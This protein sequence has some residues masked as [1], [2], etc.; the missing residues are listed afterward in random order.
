VKRVLPRLLV[1]V[2]VLGGVAAGALWWL[3]SGGGDDSE[4]PTFTVTRT[5]F[6]RAVPA[7]GNLEAVEATPI[8]APQD[9]RMPLKIA[10]MVEDGSRVEAGEVVV[11]FDPIEMEQR[12]RDGRESVVQAD[13]RIA[14]ERALSSAAQGRRD[15]EAMMA[16]LEMNAAREF[17]SKDEEVFSRH[18][19]IE[20]Q[21]DVELAGARMEHARSVKGIERSVSSGKLEVLGVQERQAQMEVDRARTALANLE[22]TAPHAGLLLIHRDWQGRTVAAGDTVWPG[23]KIAEVPGVATMEAKVY[24]LEADGGTLAEGMSA[25]VVVESQPGVEYPATIKRVDTL[26]QPRDPEVPVQYFTVILSLEQTDAAIMNIGQRVRATIVLDQTDA[27]VV[28]RQAVFTGDDGSFVYRKGA[29]GFERV[30]V[31][32]GPAT[33]GRVVI[34]EGLAEGDAIALAEPPNRG[35]P[36]AGAE[37]RLTRKETDA[38]R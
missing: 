27:L 28:P 33:A 18:E 16:E 4:V 17:E 14:K 36:D 8:T 13:S 6:R 29:G 22:L 35:G 3:G 37:A 30:A 11:R 15:R 9:A 12:L 38:A 21:V 23:M 26:A 32:L 31:T 1:A 20:S 24:V 19:I 5:E 25:T 34:T 7:D 10:W 2:V